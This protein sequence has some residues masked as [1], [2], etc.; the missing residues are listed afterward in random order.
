MEGAGIVGGGHQEERHVLVKRAAGENIE[1]AQIET[2]LSHIP[3]DLT[4]IRL[5]DGDLV[6]AVQCQFG[7]MRKVTGQYDGFCQIGE[8]RSFINW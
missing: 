7:V 3:L 2:I 1:S 6:R 4:A 8:S 5:I